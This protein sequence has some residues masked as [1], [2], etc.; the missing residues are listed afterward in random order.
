MLDRCKG[1]QSSAEIARAVREE[2]ELEE[3][4]VLSLLRKWIAAG[5]LTA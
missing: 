1:E 3:A 2:L 4:G 5:T